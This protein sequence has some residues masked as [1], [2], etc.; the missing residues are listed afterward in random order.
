MS[1]IDFLLWLRDHAVPWLDTVMGAITYLGTQYFYVAAFCFLY[2]C[3]DIAV[4]TQLFVLVL[5]SVYVRSAV[6]EITAVPRPFN[7]D[8][9]LSSKAR[10]TETATDYA[11]PSGHAVDAVVFWGYLSIVFRRRWLYILTPIVVLS[12]AFSRLYLGLHW[13]RDVLVGLLL[14]LVLLACGYVLIRFF[15][16]APLRAGFRAQLLLSLLPLLFFLL[17]PSHTAAQSMG[18]L[19]GA[20]PGHFLERRY[21]RFAVRRPVWQQAIKLLIGLG[22]ALGLLIGLGKLLPSINAGPE[23]VPVW[24]PA[25]SGAPWGPLSR[26]SAEGWTLLRYALVGLWSTLAAPAIFSRLLGREGE[27]KRTT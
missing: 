23:I 5:S 27:T 15:A 2:W 14:G 4:A 19:L 1:G 22:G 24:G 12:I 10:F 26:W 20:L 3:V 17:F 21:I 18:V 25:S 6:K 7:V 16:D 13:P 9:A 11:L 8:A